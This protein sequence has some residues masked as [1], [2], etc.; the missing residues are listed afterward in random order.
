MAT[1]SETVYIDVY[2]SDFDEDEI[3]E[4]LEYKGYTVT[5]NK[6]SESDFVEI[7]RRWETGDKKE[8]LFL[9]ERELPELYG[10]SKLIN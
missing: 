6:E 2:L 1:F 3:V 5:K 8:A 9:L 7:I 4:Y 10:I